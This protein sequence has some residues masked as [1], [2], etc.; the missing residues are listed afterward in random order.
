MKFTKF[1]LNEV[2]EITDLCL[3][4][5]NILFREK[6]KES[7]DQNENGMLIFTAEEGI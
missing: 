5:L 6:K 1:N 7:K 2:S 3:C 4:S